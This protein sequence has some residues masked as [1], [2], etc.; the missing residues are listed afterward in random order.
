MHNKNPIYKDFE[1]VIDGLIV[2]RN[3]D[4][5]KREEDNHRQAF[6]NIIDPYWREMT[7]FVKG[8]VCAKQ[9]LRDVIHEQQGC[10]KKKAK[11]AHLIT[12]YADLLDFMLSLKEQIDDALKDD[13]RN[14]E[15]LSADVQAVSRE[16][17]Q[18]AQELQ[19]LVKDKK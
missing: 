11:P 12:T 8:L 16:L 7:G 17:E 1:R 4:I 10:G 13:K 14:A 19:N 5:A 9:V 15:E 6:D 2:A 18:K 3:V